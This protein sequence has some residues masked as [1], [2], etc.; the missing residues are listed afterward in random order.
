MH[1]SVP[2]PYSAASVIM[3]PSR[4]YRRNAN[5]HNAN[6]VPLV[7]DHEV[8]NAEFRNAIQF[9]AQSVP[10]QNNQHAPVPTNATNG[11][12]TARV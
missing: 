2:D 8:S 5:A 3:L 10:N 9:L 1:T 6:A 11:Y 12:T 4:A 7:L